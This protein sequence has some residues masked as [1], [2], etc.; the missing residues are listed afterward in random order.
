[1]VFSAIFGVGIS[2]LFESLLASEIYSGVVASILGLRRP[3]A[4]G[5][6]SIP[7]RL[8]MGVGSMADRAE[9]AWDWGADVVGQ[10]E[11]GVEARGALVRAFGIEGDRLKTRR[12][13]TE[14][15]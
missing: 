11:R 8:R 7:R 13:W 12:R 4:V 9:E 10:M 2:G 5:S 14:G 15:K 6:K 1:M 3:R